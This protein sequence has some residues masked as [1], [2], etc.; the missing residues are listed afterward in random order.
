M[1]VAI[2]VSAVGFL[3]V[4]ACTQLFGLRLG[5]TISIPVLAV[6]TLKSVWT[7]PVS[8]ASAVLA[9]IGLWLLKERTLIYGRDEL[10]AAIVIGS[11]LPVGILLVFGGLLD[12]PLRAVLFIGSILPGL[13]AYN[14]HQLRDDLVL[15]DL[16]ASVGLF[17]VL[18]GV[19]ATLVSPG[20]VDTVGTFGPPVLYSSTA[21]VAVWRGVA[22]SDGLQP[23]TLGRPQT[24]AVFG[25]AMALSEIVR[26]RY[27]VRV[28]VIATGLLAV[29]ALTSVW[30]VVL[31]A[32]LFGFSY[33]AM[34]LL[35]DRTMLYG[36]VLIGLAS[37]VA[38]V[39][40]LPFVDI[41]P[42]VR[43][44]SAYFVA[45]LAGVN[46]Y[47][48]HVTSPAY[49]R[50]IPTL[51]VATFVPLLVVARLL[52]PALPRGFPQRLGPAELLVAAVVVALCLLYAEHY[53]V[54]RPSEEAV[55][56][57]SILSGGDGA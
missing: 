57:A 8:L 20:L 40:A 5:G 39:S 50:L 18:V 35:H 6:Y 21:D 52:T 13:A 1:L 12:D 42:V 48:L 46:A 23:V 25:A 27:D 54:E 24:V 53:V 2:A 31:Y 30:L 44:L 3:A 38:L 16:V 14:Y 29:Y 43:G 7:L 9:Y 34:Q 49:R 10:L 37:A 17:A 4:A 41:L 47:S 36:R 19:G 55:Y 45:I 26:N 22:V 15:P 32:V 28:G 11:A 56:E 51:Q 33:V